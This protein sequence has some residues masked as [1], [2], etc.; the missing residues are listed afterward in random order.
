MIE[1]VT[2]LDRISPAQLTGFF[3]GWPSPPT[4]ETHLEILQAA[5]HVVLALDEET[6]KV[7]GFTNAI[8][9]RIQAAYIP[10][11]EVLPEYKKKGIG[12]E[13]VKRLLAEIGDLYMIDLLCDTEVQPFYEKLGLTKAT[14]M[15]IRNFDNQAGKPRLTLIKG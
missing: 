14:G 2:T 8:S 13:L 5:D 3:V 6:G 15:R 12:A 9:D 4:A 10:L 7:V 11:L 1:Y